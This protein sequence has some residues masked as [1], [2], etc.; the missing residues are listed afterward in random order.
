MSERDV[1]WPFTKGHGTQNDFVLLP[2]P[3]G[4]LDLTPE[5]VRVLADRRNGLGGD[6]VIRVVPTACSDEPEVLALAQSAPWFMDYRNADGSPAQMCGN[7]TRVFAAY[8]RREGF[9]DADEFDIAT[10]AGVKHVRVTDDGFATNLGPWRVPHRD[11]M[12]E[13]GF[14]TLVS[15]P[16][17]DPLPALSLDLGNPHAV[18]AL[19]E[20]VDL[21]SLDL[22]RPP[23]L[24]PAVAQGSNVEFAQPL[25]P[26]HLRM[27]VHERGV[28]ETR[29]CGT[30]A[31]AAALALMLWSGEPSEHERWRVDVPGG[32]L[33]VAALP[34]GEVELS[35]P[36]ALV[37]DGQVDLQG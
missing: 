31:A 33:H 23:E 32:T 30:G 2:D 26:G 3:Q 16:G 8:L 29:S 1:R 24:N 22:T 17:L 36:A 9:V 18:V 34:G 20:S 6:G 13:R 19:P 28:G 11:L 4:H 7:G 27:R 5:R 14:D 25:G 12:C 35:G 15:V 10:R 37:A 21:D